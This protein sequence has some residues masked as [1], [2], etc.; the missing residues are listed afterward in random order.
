MGK[1]TLLG[2]YPELT[3]GSSCTGNCPGGDDCECEHTISYNHTVSN[4][5]LIYASGHCHAP[6][7]IGIWLYRN[8]PGHVPGACLGPLFGSIFAIVTLGWAR[9]NHLRTGLGVCC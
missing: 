2:P 7:C 4:M 9:F 3:P 5:R 6:A 8:D 1:H